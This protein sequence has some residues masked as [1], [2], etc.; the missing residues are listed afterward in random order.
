MPLCWMGN[1]RVIQVV[2]RQ[3]GQEPAHLSQSNPAQWCSTEHLLIMGR[4]TLLSQHRQKRMHT[5]AH[6]NVHTHAQTLMRM[7]HTTTRNKQTD[8]S[9]KTCI[10]FITSVQHTNTGAF[11]R[12]LLLR[13]L[14]QQM[15]RQRKAGFINMSHTTLQ[16]AGGSMHFGNIQFT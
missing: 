12:E 14:K 6:T 9:K 11:E 13:H 5:C 8:T 4:G 15:H 1:T 3:P 10:L 2:P 16:R 7:T